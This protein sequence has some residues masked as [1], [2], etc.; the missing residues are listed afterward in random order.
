M[1]VKIL[2]QCNFMA[3][4]FLRMC[5]YHYLLNHIAICIFVLNIV[6]DISVVVVFPT[7]Q[8]IWAQY[9]LRS[10]F[11]SFFLA[12]ESILTR[13]LKTIKKGQL[14]SGHHYPWNCVQLNFL[15]N[16]NHL[17]LSPEANAFAFGR[18]SSPSIF[19]KTP[20]GFGKGNSITHNFLLDHYACYFQGKK[21]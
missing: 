5:I 14:F 7:Y 8:I 11:W 21:D 9:I 4:F 18:K 16:S 1:L 15:E 13:S 6:K 12:L 20:D 2:Y 10:I 17:C 3:K 19:S